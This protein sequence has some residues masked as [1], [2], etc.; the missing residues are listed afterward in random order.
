MLQKYHSRGADF[1][2]KEKNIFQ[3]QNAIEQA[4]DLLSKTTNIVS[5]NLQSYKHNNSGNSSHF[6]FDEWETSTK[7]VKQLAEN[8]EL[9]IRKLSAEMTAYRR[10]FLEI[11]PNINNIN[12]T[13]EIVDEEISKQDSSINV[14][15][16]QSRALS[17]YT[18]EL[19][20]RGQSH[21]NNSNNSTLFRISTK[22]QKTE[23]NPLEIYKVSFPIKNKQEN[24]TEMQKDLEHLR[25]RRNF[26]QVHLQN[27]IQLH[28]TG[29]QTTPLTNH[30]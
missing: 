3:L 16:T 28:S 30:P 19:Q 10:I 1:I 5:Y 13:L 11:C 7:Q 29:S 22:S 20:E 24:L 21:L 12:S 4:T 8:L 25:F 17:E 14:L 15:N 26:L 18:Q 27:I 23:N 9:N 6:N 2:K